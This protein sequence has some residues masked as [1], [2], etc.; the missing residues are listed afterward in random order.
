MSDD[1][2][3]T[4]R[5]FLRR[6]S[7]RKLAAAR[8]SQPTEAPAPPRAEVAAPVVPPAVGLPSSAASEQAAA[9]PAPETLSFES[10]FT[11][12]L[13]ASVDPAV[14]S[15][16]LRRLFADP[17]FNVMD[18]LDVYIDDYGKFEPIPPELVKELR[19]A[20]YLFDPPATRMTAEGHVEDVPDV[21]SV[22]GEHAAT[23][24]QDDA[25]PAPAA[26]GADETLD[27]PAP[28]P[29]A[30]QTGSPAR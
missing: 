28:E 16:A 26:D 22:S 9:L 20:R 6:W 8:E 10:D 13:Q 4:E 25:A 18:G 15:K 7:Q 21:A 12:F 1:T 27:E 14:R 3:L 24:A 2:P 19:H 23:D 11:P 17:R 30:A 5:S 29:A